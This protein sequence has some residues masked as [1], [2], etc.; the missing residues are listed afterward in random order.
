MLLAHSRS[1]TNYVLSR[2]TQHKLQSDLQIAAIYAGLGGAQV[3]LSCESR[4]AAASVR[5]R[6]SE[7]VIQG[8]L[9]ANAA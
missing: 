3:R 9:K 6:A 7:Q 8:S 4:P 5:P 2:V 1:A